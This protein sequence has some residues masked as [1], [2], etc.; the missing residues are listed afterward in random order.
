MIEPFAPV[1]VVVHPIFDHDVDQ[2]NL[3]AAFRDQS[4]KSNVVALASDLHI[5]RLRPEFLAPFEA[6]VAQRA[7]KP[8]DKLWILR[9]SAF[10]KTASIAPLL[11]D[12]ETA[13]H[14]RDLRTHRF[15]T[16]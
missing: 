14:H 16:F 15:W 5:E 4:Y 10:L 2:I 6:C 13:V 12:R 9:S 7:L 1:V 11:I 8:H 3:T